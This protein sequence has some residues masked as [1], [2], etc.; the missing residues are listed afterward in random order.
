MKNK[1]MAENAAVVR[2]FLQGQMESGK[3]SGYPR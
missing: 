1:M 2:Q 3:Q